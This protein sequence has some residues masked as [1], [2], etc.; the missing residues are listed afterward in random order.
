MAK[1]RVITVVKHSTMSPEMEKHSILTAIEALTKYTVEQNAAR[2]IKESFDN[3]YGP[4]W[5]VVV[6][7][8]F[9]CFVSHFSSD[10]IYFYVNAVAILLYKTSAEA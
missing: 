5:Q 9:G 3:E 8:Q 2:F 1:T 7:K 10:F 6:G 4:S